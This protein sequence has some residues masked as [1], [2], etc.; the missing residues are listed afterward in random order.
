MMDTTSIALIIHRLRATLKEELANIKELK[1]QAAKSGAY[2]VA[3]IARDLEKKV[4][5]MQKMI[6]A[7][8]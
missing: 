7:V 6:A 2:E 1:N 3:V 4:V 5:E 8:G